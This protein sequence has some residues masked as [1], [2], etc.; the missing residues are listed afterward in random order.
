[1][2]E[3]INWKEYFEH[4]FF[5]VNKVNKVIN[6]INNNSGKEQIIKIKI[7]VMKDN[8][9]IK[10]FNGNEDIN[11]KNIKIFIEDNEIKFKKEIDNLK[12]NVY[13]I[14]IKIN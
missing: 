4:E 3:R 11:E 13:K 9:K 8:E 12:K 1:M 6:N 2:N 7:N 14:M 10:I 5:K